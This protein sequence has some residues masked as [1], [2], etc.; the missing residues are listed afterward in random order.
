MS[1][2]GNTSSSVIHTD[3]FMTGIKTFA[4]LC[5]VIGALI[6]VL[7]IMKRLM[8]TENNFGRN[9]FIKIMASYHLAPK[10]RVA[11]IDVVGEKLIVGVTQEN[12]TCLGK[13][14]N[15]ECLKKIETFEKTGRQGRMFKKLL[16]ASFQRE[17]QPTGEKNE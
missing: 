12:I 17:K 1:D 15:E 14:E 3:L 10:Q 2:F 16:T 11:I 13:I 4:T 9:G 8:K 7:Y 6:L 5:L